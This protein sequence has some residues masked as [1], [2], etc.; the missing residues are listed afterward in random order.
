[1]FFT[2]EGPLLLEFGLY[3][4]QAE[5][6]FELPSG[7]PELFQEENFVVDIELNIGG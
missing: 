2:F 7:H 1:M 6:L 4:F 3:P 5:E